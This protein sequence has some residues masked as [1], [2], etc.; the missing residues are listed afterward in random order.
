MKP[1]KEKTEKEGIIEKVGASVNPKVESSMNPKLYDPELVDPE[2]ILICRHCGKQ[3][4]QSTLI[5]LSLKCPSCGKPQNGHPKDPTVDPYDEM[6]VICKHCNEPINQ[7]KL[8]GIS[9]ICPLCKMPRNGLPH[10]K[11]K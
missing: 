3:I 9:L 2:L 4:D 10:P 5:G 6:T 8:R 1:I 11:T 7:A